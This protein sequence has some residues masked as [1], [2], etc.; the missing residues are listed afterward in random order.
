M[1]IKAS[2]V[3]SEATQKN[4]ISFLPLLSSNTKSNLKMLNVSVF[5]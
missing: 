5:L 4:S 2:E 3:P 1:L